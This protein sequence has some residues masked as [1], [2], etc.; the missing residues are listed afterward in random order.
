MKEIEYHKKVDAINLYFHTVNDKDKY[1]LLEG[2]F[3]AFIHD[4]LGV[5]I[6]GI[7]I[8]DM[9]SDK[10]ILYQ[11]QLIDDKGCFYPR[12][13]YNS[14]GEKYEEFLDLAFIGNRH[15]DL[16]DDYK[17]EPEFHE[18]FN[19]AAGEKNGDNLILK[20]V[21]ALDEKGKF[22]FYYCSAG[23]I[24]FYLYAWR[25]LVRL[26]SVHDLSFEIKSIEDF[27]YLNYYP[28]KIDKKE[29]FE[30]VIG[31]DFDKIFESFKAFLNNTCNA[32]QSIHDELSEA[33]KKVA[34]NNIE[35]AREEYIDYE[36]ESIG[37]NNFIA[38][39]WGALGINPYTMRGLL[40]LKA[41][42]EYIIFICEEIMGEDQRKKIVL[43]LNELKDKLLLL[44][45]NSF[46]DVD[47]NDL[48]QQQLHN[49]IV[50]IIYIYFEINGKKCGE[51]IRGE[52]GNNKLLKRFPV[53]PYFLEIFFDKN[54]GLKESWH[55]PKEHLVF[56][57]WYSDG[58]EE[59][60]FVAYVLLSMDPVWSKADNY[61]AYG[62]KDEQVLN[63][64]RVKNLF[65][66]INK[67]LVETGFY[68]NV[69]RKRL[70]EPSLRAAISQ[71]MARNASHNIG[72]HVLNKIIN[73]VEGID[74]QKPCYKS[75]INEELS[76]EIIQNQGSIKE[77]EWL[78]FIDFEDAK[79][80]IGEASG[81]I[82]N[83]N[84]TIKLLTEFNKYVKHRM[85]YLSDIALGTP[86]MQTAKSIGDI[87]KGIDN[88]RLL[89]ENISGLSD[90]D[91]TIRCEVGAD[92]IVA[93]PNDLL[94]S[95]AF[96]NVIENIIRNTAK[97][98]KDIKK[99]VIFT[100]ALESY[101]DDLYKVSIYDDLPY[102]KND[103]DKI[104]K[105]QNDKI[106]MP[107][108]G[109]D[110][111]L[112][113][114]SLGMAEMKASAS[115][116]RKT[117]LSEIDLDMHDPK[118][119]KAEKQR[120]DNNHYSLKYELYF[121][122]PKEV[123]FVVSDIR[124]LMLE[125]EQ[126]KAGFELLSIDAFKESIFENV[127]FNHRYLVYDNDSI[128][129]I[130][131][132]KKY[133]GF[134]PIRCYQVGEISEILKKN[135]DEVKIDISDCWLKKQNINVKEIVSGLPQNEGVIGFDN[136]I[137][138]VKIQKEVNDILLKNWFYYWEAFNSLGM[139]YLP[140]FNALRN[141][142]MQ[143]QYLDRL[144]KRDIL[145]AYISNL[146]KGEDFLRK[147]IDNIITKRRI[148]LNELAESAATKILIID[149][150]IQKSGKM[151]F[152][153]VTHAR[154]YRMVNVFIPDEN[155][156]DLSKK[157]LLN[158]KRWFD[159][160]GGL[161]TIL[162][163]FSAIDFL[164]IHYGILE[165]ISGNNKKKINNYLT[166]WSNKCQVVVTSGRSMPGDLPGDIRFLNLSSL[167]NAFIDIR[168]KYYIIN[169]LHDTRK[170]GR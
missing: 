131:E 27:Y 8:Y 49:A 126:K 91:Y 51:I 96:Y 40:S 125:Y 63:I 75:S 148:A 102:E 129:A 1:N 57:V 93:M 37:E 53:F 133:K 4:E 33:Q 95:Q 120:L 103:I 7:M 144:Y 67:S 62:D 2:E 84:N 23:E 16:A 18:Y 80:A 127:V 164:I 46:N 111:K 137:N 24:L 36:Y 158:N 122:K 105:E 167:E 42:V 17:D 72:S 94:G 13:S 155:E 14:A 81:I 90:F 5:E 109:K 88:V 56:P 60:R 85:D 163:D 115:Y 159:P 74:W 149:E 64:Y 30:V 143:D 162:N 108:I 124:S 152:N 48:Y 136:H 170:P 166:V 110:Y 87:M 153:N 116:L 26:L 61:G 71:I 66:V 11:N 128:K 134:L 44:N 117:N 6:S 19:V 135:N 25:Y 3:A 145:L 118:L 34:V 32:K 112:R 38:V 82:K 138:D 12:I 28:Q 114:G 41:M 9:E 147:N 104:V 83:K 31:Y 165:R 99:K 69:L 29:W 86:V 140:Y 52:A 154:L 100:V 55:K 123:L 121:L 101:N 68:N 76:S 142:D 47:Y 156:I 89:L 160:N 113:H 43:E 107:I 151:Q 98:G 79:R 146:N 106:K 161:D 59:R 45:K 10:H 70:L 78:N 21:I 65:Q 157:C 58:F 22:S 77:E 73:N 35:K 132:D 39:E 15:K 119:L 141:S 97:H 169:C 139:Q 92:I 20:N 150:R 54:D 50:K 168:N 130:V